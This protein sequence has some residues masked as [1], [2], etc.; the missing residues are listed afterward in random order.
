MQAN[1]GKIA[2]MARPRTARSRR[3]VRDELTVSHG[4][5]LVEELLAD[6]K[7]AAEYLLA[8]AEDSDHRVYCAAPHSPSHSGLFQAA[9][10]CRK[11]FSLKGWNFRFE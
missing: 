9:S 4:E 10:A 8:A 6:P 7:L 3:R 2:A 1:S 5:R 11:T